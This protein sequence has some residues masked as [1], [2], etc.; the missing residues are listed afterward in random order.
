MAYGMQ[1]ILIKNEI[2]SNIM[3]LIDYMWLNEN[4]IA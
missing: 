2:I 3:N 4:K 1:S